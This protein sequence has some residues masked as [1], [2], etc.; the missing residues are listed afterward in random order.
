MLELFV[1]HTKDINDL[2]VYVN[3]DTAKSNKLTDGSVVKIEN[4]NNLQLFTFA[5]VKTS[6]DI[7]KD[8]ILMG[9]CFRE[10]LSVS[11]FDMVKVQTAEKLPSAKVVEIAPVGGSFRGITGDKL[12]I[13]KNSTLDLLK[14][15]VY[16]QYTFPVAAFSK[17]FEFQVV[18]CEP[19]VAMVNNYDCIEIVGDENKKEI[20]Q[21]TYFEDFGGEDQKLSSFFSYLRDIGKGNDSSRFILIEAP[22]GYGKTHLL[23]ALQTELRNFVLFPISIHKLVASNF[24]PRE[25]NEIVDKVRNCDMPCSIVIDDM[26]VA[27]SSWYD[28]NL[29]QDI[30]VRECMESLF[31]VNNKRFICFATCTERYIDGLVGKFDRVFVFGQ[32]DYEQRLDIAKRISSRYGITEARFIEWV[33]RS[34][35]NGSDIK[36]AINS[37]VEE[38]CLSLVSPDLING[39]ISV[40]ELQA[41]FAGYRHENSDINSMIQEYDQLPKTRK[42]GSSL[43]SS[44]VEKVTNSLSMIPSIG[45]DDDVNPFLNMG[46]SKNSTKISGGMDPFKEDIKSSKKNSSSDDSSDDYNSDDGSSKGKSVG[47]S[48]RGNS[49]NR[50]NNHNSPGDIAKDKLNNVNPFGIDLKDK[51]NGGDPFRD[52]I[53]DKPGDEDPFRSGIGDKPSTNNPFE[54]DIRVRPGRDDPF[55]DGLKSELDSRDPFDSSPR[56]DPIGGALGSRLGTTNPFEDAIAVRL[57][58]KVEIPVDKSPPPDTSLDLAGG[59]KKHVVDPFDFAPGRKIPGGNPFDDPPSGIPRDPHPDVASSDV[60]AE[61]IASSK[62]RSADDFKNPP[63][64]ADHDKVMVAVLH[65]EDPLSLTGGSR[66]SDPFS[67]RTKQDDVDIFSR[68]KPAGIMSNYRKP[69]GSVDF[70]MDYRSL[71]GVDTVPLPVQSSNNLSGEE[72]DHSRVPR[73]V[74]PPHQVVSEYD[75]DPFAPLQKQPVAKQTVKPLDR[76]DPFSDN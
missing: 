63:P 56:R 57:D 54:N 18:K 31:R 10:T 29:S 67:A 43:L 65:D 11:F 1:E 23:R 8:K 33:A 49:N 13:I 32:L 27:C 35:S 48:P 60:F 74:D 72:A 26:D 24:N 52:N 41:S 66:T 16:K 44:A 34:S 21:K 3:E 61:E 38:R 69:S 14:K 55:G 5:A 15:P 36:K 76:R 73:D 39:D 37:Y 47:K 53:K 40:N 17:V 46:D 7:E 75:K 50:L 4:R 28:D 19:A 58:S 9:A 2:N 62:R 59:I 64:P 22:K 42:R 20:F 70:A 45:Q 68:E 25:F 71:V 6:P 51:P 30:R 12:T